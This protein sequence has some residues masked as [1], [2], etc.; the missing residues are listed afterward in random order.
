[1]SKVMSLL[2]LTGTYLRMVLRGVYA[3]LCL[4]G[5][6]A[7]SLVGRG[8]T[9]QSRLIARLASP[10]GLRLG[11]DV[12][13]AFVPTLALRRKIVT[14]YDNTGT[15]IVA[16]FD[17][18][19]DVLHRDQDFEVVYAPRMMSITGGGNFFLGMQDSPQYRRDVSNM[20]LA[21]RQDD[22]ST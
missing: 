8:Q 10:S 9:I 1:M 22:L 17:D 21:V 11:F 19:K 12:L 13:R 14:A 6:A 5:I 4:S 2:S 15:A 16:R 20:R 18:V 7:A 3:L